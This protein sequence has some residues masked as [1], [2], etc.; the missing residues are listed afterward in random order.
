MASSMMQSDAQTLFFDVRHMKAV[1]SELDVCLD[2]AS[3][4][5]FMACVSVCTLWPHVDERL[6]TRA[7]ETLLRGFDNSIVSCLYKF[8]RMMR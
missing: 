8:M 1:E 3:F 6:R 7:K 5:I 2:N 4:L